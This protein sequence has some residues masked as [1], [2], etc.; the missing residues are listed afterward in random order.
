MSTCSFARKGCSDGVTCA[1]C[2]IR[3]A[4]EEASCTVCFSSNLRM[5]ALG[6]YHLVHNTC[7]GRL[8]KLWPIC[9]ARIAS[10]LEVIL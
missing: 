9:Q 10:H 2:L 8:T 3:S 1:R 5:A 4:K 6:C 7:F